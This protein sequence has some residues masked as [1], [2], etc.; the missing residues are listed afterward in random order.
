MATV[1]PG[2][3][4]QD[5]SCPIKQALALK[6]AQSLYRTVVSLTAAMFNALTFSVSGF[7]LSY[8]AN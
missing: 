5:M 8:V 1:R 3:A 4:Q 6:G 2:F 7:A